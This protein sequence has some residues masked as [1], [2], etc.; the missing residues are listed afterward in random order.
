M[1]TQDTILVTGF[2]QVPKGTTLYEIYKTMAVA[3]VINL[4]TEV[5]EDAEFT[6]TTD[7]MNYYLSDLVKGYDLK[8]GINPLLDTVKKHCIIPSQGALVQALRSAWD[9]YQESKPNR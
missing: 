3:M 4:K 5:I 9:R 6:C 8:Q 7:L 1:K 2:A